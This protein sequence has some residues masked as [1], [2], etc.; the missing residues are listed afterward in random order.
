M[1]SAP[2]RDH[3]ET[4][5]S[6]IRLVAVRFGI[7]YFPL[8]WLVLIPFPLVHQA[9]PWAG[10]HILHLGRDIT[11]FGNIDTTY[12]Y[13]RTFFCLVLAAA[14]SAIW[15]AVHRKGANNEMLHR[16][17]RLFVRTMLV[18]AMSLYG[19][20]K[21]FH[22]QMGTPSLSTLLE[23]IG[24]MSPFTLLWTF[25]G[26]SHSYE[27]F[28]GLV[29][30]LPALLLIVPRF[31]TLGALISATV[32]TNVFV[33]NLSYDVPV[34]IISFHLFLMS[35]VLLLPDLP[36][37]ANFFVLNRTAEP[38]IHPA[39]T[40]RR[41]INRVA[42]VLPALVF[43][44]GL[45]IGLHKLVGS[46]VLVR[47]R[48]AED[49]SL[50]G[51]WTVEE[52]AEDSRFSQPMLTPHPHWQML[53]FENPRRAILQSADGSRTYLKLNLGSEKKEFS[54]SDSDNPNWN[55]QFAFEKPE[56]DSL[57]LHGSENGHV[58][59]AKLHRVT[60]RFVLT[61]RGLHWINENAYWH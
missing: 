47:E 53:V 56:A 60:P 17:L 5:W 18:F 13:L 38:A 20:D 41:W 33:T 1:E 9:V 26:V 10:K 51:A 27:M 54:L 4:R 45:A 39:L 36:R 25:M 50:N 58:I 19:W 14:A 35:W 6:L 7:V 15:S 11:A 12:N 34:K 23:P 30:V 40:T 21:A 52:F 24:Q 49:Q 8:F 55:A 3:A 44:I 16:W 57:Y 29:E 28:A 42:L 46:A 32:M 31:A 59:H 61:T 37:L 2:S 22:F 43:L 48:A